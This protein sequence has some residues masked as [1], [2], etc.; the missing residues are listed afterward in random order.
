MLLLRK[1]MTL[2]TSRC[3]AT[4]HARR[5]VEHVISAIFLRAVLE[6]AEWKWWVFPQNSASV[7][8]RLRAG[9]R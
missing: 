8:R 3:G 5:H 7:L 6:V 9:R 4:I 2:A 1:G